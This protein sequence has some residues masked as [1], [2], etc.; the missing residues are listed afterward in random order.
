[1]HPPQ[2]IKT[3][4]E[5]DIILI[6]ARDSKAQG[7]IILY[8]RDMGIPEEKICLK[9][10]QTIYYPEETCFTDGSLNEETDSLIIGFYL[11]YGGL[12]DQIIA[13]KL[14]QELCRM[15]PGSYIDIFTTRKVFTDAVYA[16][17]PNLRRIFA[18]EP[19]EGQYNEYDL[20]VEVSAQVFIKSINVNRIQSYSM[21]F[22]E[23]ISSHMA[24]QDKYYVDIPYGS[25]LD[26]VMLKR[27]K[28][29]GKN[30][31]TLY[32]ASAMFDITDSPAHIVINS[33]YVKDY[34][35]ICPKGLYATYNYGAQ[36]VK[37]GGKKQTK[38]WPAEYHKSLNKLF[39]NKYPD[40][41][42]VQIGAEECENIPG[43]DAYILG[44]NLEVVKHILKHSMFHF[45]C[46]GGLVHLATQLGTK[47]IVIFGPTPIWYLG[48]EENINIGPKQCGE[49]MAASGSW[50]ECYC[51][52]R[53]EC[54]YSIKPEVV[55]EHI[56][57]YMKDIQSYG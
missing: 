24:H 15:I 32:D 34:E 41:A 4:K 2:H 30:K 29:R 50:F 54:M 3:I 36:A 47:C 13:L 1:M 5:F 21:T 10:F 46:E 17:Q 37:R 38:M 6:S 33:E 55:M 25:Y 22:F 39:K 48:Y 42:L 53:P 20:F 57:S 35:D 40:I 8:L 26:I 51:F 9:T 7:E 49:C 14:Y 43:A 12:G 18:K 27:A 45:D 19:K 11:K 44:E 23:K 28:L 31:Y 16:G 52:D 56:D